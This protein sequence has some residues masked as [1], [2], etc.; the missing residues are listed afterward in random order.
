[1][2]DV[3]MSAITFAE[4]QSDVGPPTGRLKSERHFE[5]AFEAKAEE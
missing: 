3:V 4:L 1:M 2:G 5:V